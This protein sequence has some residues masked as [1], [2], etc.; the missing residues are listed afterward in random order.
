MHL[1]GVGIDLANVSPAPPP[2]RADVTMPSGRLPAG[3]GSF[4]DYPAFFGDV[5]PFCATA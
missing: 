1:S 2:V 5:V 3:I 4:R